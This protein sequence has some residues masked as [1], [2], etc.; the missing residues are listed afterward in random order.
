MRDNY[1]YLVIGSGPAGYTSAI[2]AA[3]SGL[4]TALVEKDP[5]MLG[6]VCLNE[7]CIPA[8]SLYN[9]A[10]ILNIAKNNLDIFGSSILSGS[11]PMASFVVKSREA[12]GQLKQGL[13]FLL[14]K[15]GIDIINAKAEFLN[16]CTIK[17][18]G[19]EGGESAV[20]ADKFLIATGSSARQLREMPFDG[21]KF[22]SSSH[23]IRLE[24]IPG[25]LLIVGAG[26]IGTEFASFFNIMGSSV[27]L[28]EVE[29]VILPTEDKDV[30]D[31]LRSIFTKKGIKVVTSS[32]PSDIKA[33]DFDVVLVSVGRVPST[34]GI[35]LEKAGIK[36]DEKGFIPVDGV[37]CTNV[38]NIYAAGDV[39]STPMLAHMA[40]AEGEVAA[41][42]ALG[43]DPEEIDLSSVPN[44]VY[45]D[46]QAAS[47]GFTEQAAREKGIEF[48]IG[49]QFFKANGKAVV[50]RATEGFIKVLA[51]NATRKIIGA[52]ILGVNATEMIHEFALAKRKG[53]TV[54]DIYETVHAHPTFSES[55]IDA[56]KSVFGKPVHG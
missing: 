44:A 8:K 19:P 29:P 26:A 7:G 55:A 17:L 13:S 46:I 32:D 21:K 50:D 27:T 51:E 1:D 12:T 20:K 2:I 34:S 11:D 22:I 48:S 10:K 45:G 54:D 35:G 30:S 24:K 33:E 37:M 6:G 25:K 4:K 18:T 31:G 9:S 23:A 56:A 52:H 41:M 43:K 47:V 53:L 40:S 39:L 14:K 49:K 15:N 42:S 36:T 3:Q 28:L 5:A 16:A 38:E